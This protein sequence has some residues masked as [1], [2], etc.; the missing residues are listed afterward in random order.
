MAGEISGLRRGLAHRASLGD[1]PP[2]G[3]GL[4]VLDHSSQEAAT[5]APASSTTTVIFTLPEGAS[6]GERLRDHILTHPVGREIF[7]DAKIVERDTRGLFGS[8]CITARKSAA[9]AAAI[10]GDA[11]SFIDPLYSPGSIFALTRP[12]L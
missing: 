11:A 7:R 9:T 1:E 3:P 4:V 12:R 6:L 10:V 8:A 2:H 5:S